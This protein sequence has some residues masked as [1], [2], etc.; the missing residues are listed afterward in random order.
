MI[1]IAIL[2]IV[3]GILIK[4]GKMHFLIAGYNTMPK[5]KKEKYDIEGIASVFRN[6]MFGMALVLIIG[7]FVSEEMENPKIE[8]YSLYIA[9]AIGLPYL[10]ILSNSDKFKNKNDR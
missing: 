2:F 3:L 1:P 7:Y 8:T 9:I 5:V 6:A 4:Y 10:L